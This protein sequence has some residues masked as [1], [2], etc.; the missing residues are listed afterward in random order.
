MSHGLSARILLQ[1][2]ELTIQ[3][4][5]SFLQDGAVSRMARRLDVVQYVD[6]GQAQTFLL[7]PPF[8]ICLERA[9]PAQ[10]L[11]RALAGFDLRF[12]GFTFPSSSHKNLP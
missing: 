12:Y 7:A 4:I 9:I 5:E 10:L 1:P 3:M 6:S 8:G 2:G 11:V